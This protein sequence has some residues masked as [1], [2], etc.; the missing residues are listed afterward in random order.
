MEVTMNQSSA[1]GDEDPGK[2]YR[3]MHELFDE[4]KSRSV[5]G[6]AGSGEVTI[7]TDVTPESAKRLANIHRELADVSTALR[8]FWTT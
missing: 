3:R 7:T 8:K 2:L 1:Q 6:V 5:Y 4:L